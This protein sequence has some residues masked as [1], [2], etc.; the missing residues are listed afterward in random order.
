M[1]AYKLIGYT[2]ERD[3]RF[4]EVNRRLRTMHAEIMDDTLRKIQK[5]G[6]AAQHD[7]ATDL[8]T[9]NDSLK[10]S[11][12]ICRCNETQSGALSWNMRLDSGLRPDITVAVRMDDKNEQPLDYYI[13]PAID[14]ENPTIRLTRHNGFALDAYRFDNLEPFFLLAEHT[15]LR[16][17]A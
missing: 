14:I 1:R 8:L 15:A 11:I 6:G 9:I 16:E 17:V 4:V 13:L 12:V 3:Y 5:L 7:P 10:V 2:P